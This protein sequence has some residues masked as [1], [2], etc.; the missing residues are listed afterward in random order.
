MRRSLQFV[1]EVIVKMDLEL[2]R[3]DSYPSLAEGAVEIAIEVD[4]FVGASVVPGADNFVSVIAV[5]RDLS[6]F[7]VGASHAVLSVVVQKD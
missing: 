1:L 3:T 7:V 5:Q 6:Q 4:S 2:E